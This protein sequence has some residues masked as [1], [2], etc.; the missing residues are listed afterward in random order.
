MLSHLDL[1]PA[2]LD[3][4][5]LPKPKD[6]VLDG[7][8]CLPALAGQAPSPHER[9]VFHLGDSFALREGSLKIIRPKAEAPWELYDLASDPG[10]AINLAAERPA[11]VER[12]SG[13]LTRWRTEVKQDASERVIYKR[14][15]ARP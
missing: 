8:N 11:D 2:F 10:E 6:R 12:C 5:G 4:S 14:K 1:L 7:R 15:N 13:A 9:M 3:V